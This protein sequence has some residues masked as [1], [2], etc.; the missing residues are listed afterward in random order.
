M[1]T[2]DVIFS[3]E[4]WFRPQFRRQPSIG[5]D[6]DCAVVQVQKKN[7]PH[8]WNDGEREKWQEVG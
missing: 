3:T 7:T 1:D 4:K 8:E 5:Q 6:R 2:I